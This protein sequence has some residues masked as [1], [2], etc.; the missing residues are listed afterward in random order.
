MPKRIK[1]RPTRG[2]GF[3]QPQI[4]GHSIIAYSDFFNN[5]V[6]SSIAY[7]TN[8]ILD[9]VS[10]DTTINV[11]DL[12]IV[13]QEIL[14]DLGV[15]AN[16]ELF[17]NSNDNSPFNNFSTN[18]SDR[19]TTVIT[20]TTVVIE[21]IIFEKIGEVKDNC[22]EKESDLVSTHNNQIQM[23]TEDYETQI[24]I[25]KGGEMGNQYGLAKEEV[26]EIYEKF[27]KAYVNK[28]P[29]YLPNMNVFHKYYMLIDAKL[30]EQY[31]D[32][33]ILLLYR[34]I[35]TSLVQ[36]RTVFFE[37]IKLQSEVS[38][39]RKYRKEAKYKILELTKELAEFC[40]KTGGNYFQ[41]KIGI[42][43]KKPKR[44][45]YAQAL[46]NI[47]MAWY[48][49]LHDTAKIESNQYVSTIAYVNQLG[50]EAY[51][52]LI[53]LL[54]ERFETLEDFLEEIEDKVK[55]HS[56]NS[57]CSDTSSS[58]S[59]SDT[60]SS[61]SCSDTT[62]SSCSDTTSGSDVWTTASE[63]EYCDDD[64]PY[65]PDRTF[66]EYSLY[67][68]LNPINGEKMLQL[69]G[70]VSLCTNGKFVKMNDY[71]TRKRNRKVTRL[72]YVLNPIN[73]EKMLRLT[74]KVCVDQLDKF[75]L[76]KTYRK[77]RKK[78]KKKKVLEKICYTIGGYDNTYITNPHTG[79]KM[80]RLC[81]ELY[82]KQMGKFTIR[83]KTR[84]KK[85]KKK[86]RKTSKKCDTT[87][88]YE[89]DYHDN[90]QDKLLYVIHPQTG[91]RCLVINGEVYMKQ[92]K[93]FQTK[94]ITNTP[95]CEQESN[96]KT[97]YNKPNVH[98]NTPTYLLDYKSDTKYLVLNG[99]INVNQLPQFN[100]NFI[101]NYVK[102]HIENYN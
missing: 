7:T 64:Q 68:V 23:L 4:T 41:G 96:S 13:S 31:D 43:L 30:K 54:D 9:N 60:S 66:D 17:P 16:K 56:D 28:G 45:I 26:M 86:K 37:N 21:T 62:S 97:F 50:P 59:C 42:K 61:S 88:I 40:K 52:T 91:N 99:C 10:K 47:N 32:D 75:S 85:H 2:Y 22:E 95:H 19:L 55:I 70:S 6:S 87:K 12:N 92:L 29:Y 74:G 98:Q 44:L 65:Y 57:S 67:Y 79:Q 77:K 80:L 72:S 3:F 25:L 89:N 18:F 39:L 81:G 1:T 38:A 35:L 5:V 102:N 53:T 76:R 58:S 69:G 84:K 11:P 49:Y 15:S 93:R 33:F 63:G 24:A 46:L 94:Y 78:K 34:D 20:E 101:Y 71:Y 27:V 82:V 48:I 8:N 73:G 100:K 36:N 14:F 83:K 51:K 90:I